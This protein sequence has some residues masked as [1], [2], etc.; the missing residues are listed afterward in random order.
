MIRETYTTGDI[1]VQEGDD[2]N[3]IFVLEGW[4]V[5]GISSEII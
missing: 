2:A 5:I 4:D 3:Q 1:I